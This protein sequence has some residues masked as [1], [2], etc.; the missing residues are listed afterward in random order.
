MIQ[1]ISSP[2]AGFRGALNYV[3]AARKDPEL[4]GGNMAGETARELAAEFGHGRERNPAVGKP[5]FHASLTAAPTDRLLEAD[6]RRLA[7]AYLQ[8]LGYGDSQWVLVRH[9]DT[10]H[11]HVHIVA[12]RVNGQGKRVPDFQER[13]R[14]EAMVRELER[15][16]SLAPV[17]PS[18]ERSRGAPSRGELAAFERTGQVSVR[19]RLQ[20]HVDLAARGGPSLAEFAERLSAQ[21]VG[22][23]AHVATTE[24]L[25]GLS[26]E[27]DGV[28]CKG[29]DL[30]RGYSWQGLAARTG[31]SYEPA[32]DLPRLRA[33]GAVAV[34]ES[35]SPQRVEIGE[36]MDAGQGKTPAVPAVR[37]ERPTILMPAASWERTDERVPTPP[38]RGTRTSSPLE[39]E[40]VR[41]RVRSALD[42]AAQGGPALPELIRRLRTMGIT[43]QANLARTGQ[44]SGLRYEC[45]GRS[46]KGSELGRDYSWRALSGRHGI[47]S[48]L[49]RDV[50]RLEHDGQV[51]DGGLAAKSA[52]PIAGVPVFRAAA[53]LTSRAE[54][55]ARVKVLGEQTRAPGEV[56]AEARALLDR[57]AQEER[58][59]VVR[60]EAVAWGL[61][62]AYGSP[63]AAGKALAALVA[64]EGGMRAAEILEQSPDQL[65]R[66][67]GLGVGSLCTAQRREALA[68]AGWLARELRTAAEWEKRLSAGAPSADAARLRGELAQQQLQQ[69]T[70]ATSRLPHARTLEAEMVRAAG[71]LGPR[72][73]AR[74]VPAVRAEGLLRRALHQVLDRMISRAQ[75]LYLGR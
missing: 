51:P 20:E 42:A 26:F 63:E 69:L 62:A 68:G 17:A 73:T 39:M 24:R 60:P 75:N 5:V 31:L 72:M 65:G 21:G 4:I 66:L 41:D 22:V 9:H 28:S 35:L 67:R 33:L 46:L 1:K 55:E 12:N 52:A 49:E 25:S 45:E 36:T 32:R 53:V 23:R 7:E 8:R 44:L 47:R 27:L 15:S 57:R 54:V 50:P 71:V 70:T 38:A 13:K 30:G 6:W 3:L 56:T 10:E 64:R 34:R 2:G 59:A 19:A 40:K 48:E 16:M 11:D 61:R 14:G 74:L 43:A 58:R 37:A 29:S 18:R